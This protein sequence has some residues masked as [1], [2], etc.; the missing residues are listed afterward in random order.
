M[1]S[2]VKDFHTKMGIEYDVDFPKDKVSAHIQE[3]NLTVGCM[4]RLASNLEK[5][6]LTTSDGRLMAMHLIL[7]E[8]LETIKALKD[9]NELE[10]LDGL[11]DLIY[12]CASAGVRFGWDVDEAF[13]RVHDSNMTKHGTGARCR[14]KGDDF[15]PANL[16]DLV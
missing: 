13:N 5:A 16:E 15:I 12:V 9:G 4:D 1:L 2:E 11:A 10:S 6:A 7:E 3:W 8:S 14:G